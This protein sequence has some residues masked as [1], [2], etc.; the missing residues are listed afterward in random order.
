MSQCTKDNEIKVDNC[1]P[2]FTARDT[3][4]GLAA[5][6]GVGLLASLALSAIIL[7]LSAN[8][9]AQDNISIY[10]QHNSVNL[11]LEK[12]DK[13]NIIDYSTPRSEE[14]TSELQSH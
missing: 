12:T 6:L 10:P 5:C 13:P 1:P 11:S 2:L 14:H 9:Q 8:A 4:I 7:L 3:C